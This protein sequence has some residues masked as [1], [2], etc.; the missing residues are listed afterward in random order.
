[1]LVVASE[2]PAPACCPTWVWRQE[3][4]RGLLTSEGKGHLYGIWKAHAV[5]AQAD[6]M[7]LLASSSCNLVPRDIHSGN[8]QIFEHLGNPEVVSPWVEL[9]SALSMGPHPLYTSAKGR[10]SCRGHEAQRARLE[11]GCRKL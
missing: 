2:E 6:F 11:F 4:G 7:L 10:L 5:C 3:R 9:S 1:M 8:L